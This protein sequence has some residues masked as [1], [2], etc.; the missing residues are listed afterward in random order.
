M[1][2]TQN[3]NTSTISILFSLKTVVEQLGGKHF[4]IPLLEMVSKKSDIIEI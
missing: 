1:S 4:Q 3:F 2:L